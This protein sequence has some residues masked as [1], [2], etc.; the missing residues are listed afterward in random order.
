[1]EFSASVGCIREDLEK[2]SNAR[3]RGGAGDEKQDMIHEKF[4][5]RKSLG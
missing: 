5:L 3:G 1:M 2:P 4:L